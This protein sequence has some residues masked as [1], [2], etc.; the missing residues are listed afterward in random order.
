MLL[1]T[2]GWPIE[3]EA[4]VGGGEQ[5]EGCSKVRCPI[6][7]YASH[8]LEYIPPLSRFLKLKK[9][10]ESY[11]A[12]G[13]FRISHLLDLYLNNTNLP[14][15]VQSKFVTEFITSIYLITEGNNRI[16]VIFEHLPSTSQGT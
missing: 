5:V 15:S 14:L 1:F 8:R 9:Y 10:R 12:K 7:L 13:S 4:H 3:L 11:L 6:W 2:K 16:Q